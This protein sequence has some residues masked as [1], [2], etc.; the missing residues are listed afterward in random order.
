MT[1]KTT[2]SIVRNPPHTGTKVHRI[3]VMT[4]SEIIKTPQWAEE[5]IGKISLAM[6]AIA[7]KATHMATLY[8]QALDRDPMFNM[9]I[10]DAMP[11]IP[12]GFWRRLEK[13]GR[14]Q[15]DARLASGA[16][17]ATYLERMPISEQRTALDGQ[18]E[19]LTGTGDTLLVRLHTL[20]PEKA[21]QVFA[22]DHIRTPEEQKVWMETRADKERADSA[23]KARRNHSSVEINKSKKL[24][25]FTEPITL[26]VAE[27]MEYARKVME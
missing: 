3:K 1:Q 25:T 24:V 21:N 8:V 4:T 26:T 19:M 16:P 20:T 11:T 18:I 13:A 14:G 9:Y 15:I 23:K 22:L 17:Y 6:S 2:L 5:A 7:E 27:L 12:G 10:R